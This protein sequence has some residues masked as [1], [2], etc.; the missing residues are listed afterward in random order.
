MRTGRTGGAGTGQT[1][2]DWY[3]VL[4]QRPIAN[5]ATEF[6][7]PG[8]EMTPPA[9]CNNGLARAQHAKD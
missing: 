2:G 8:F 3:L 4:P 7:G 6:D 1:R 9:N 5:R